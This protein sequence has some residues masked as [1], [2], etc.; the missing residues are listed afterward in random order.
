MLF[1][2]SHQ[3]VWQ[4]SDRATSDSVPQM[5]SGGGTNPT[6]ALQEAAKVLSR[7]QAP[8]KVMITLTDGSWSGDEDERQRLM[9]A[10]HRDGIITM[11][12]GFGGAFDR[13]GKHGHL[14]G[15]DI[16][17]L[18]ELPKM[19]TKLVAQIMRQAIYAA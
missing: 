11:L 18:S 10:M 13:Y 17:R 6:S 4:P 12:L 1:D 2:T 16:A 5:Y 15:H 14:E 7:S 9:R 3:I 8:N 19:A